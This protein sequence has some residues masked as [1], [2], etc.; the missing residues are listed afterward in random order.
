MNMWHIH[1]YTPIISAVGLFSTFSLG[2]NPKYNLQWDLKG[3]EGL[4]HAGMLIGCGGMA[5][6]MIG[7]GRR[8]VFFLLYNPVCSQIRLFEA[9]S[10][11]VLMFFFVSACK[12]IPW[13]VPFLP[14]EFY[15]SICRY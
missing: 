10:P 9:L 4:E 15:N 1:G 14:V 12:G 13:K 7:V 6:T 8:S 5:M 3:I 11:G 2:C